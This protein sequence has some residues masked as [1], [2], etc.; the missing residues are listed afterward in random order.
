MAIIFY[1][2]TPDIS[3]G[4]AMINQPA[5]WRGFLGGINAVSM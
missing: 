1:K 2:F 4:L 3:T 5:Q